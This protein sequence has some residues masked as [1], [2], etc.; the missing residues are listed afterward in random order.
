MITEYFYWSLTS[1]LG[2]QIN[3]YDEIS[4]EWE[5]NTPSKMTKDKLIMKILQDERYQI[6]KRLPSF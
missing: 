1:L 4:E 2:A 3:R 6:P 5:L